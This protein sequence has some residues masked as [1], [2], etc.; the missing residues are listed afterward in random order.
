[1]TRIFGVAVILTAV[2]AVRPGDLIAQSQT[3]SAK[4]SVTLGAYS[5]NFAEPNPADQCHFGGSGAKVSFSFQGEVVNPA[6]PYTVA[7]SGNFSMYH[8]DTG[9]RTQFLSGTALIF[10]NYHRLEVNGTCETRNAAGQIVPFGTGNCFI[11]SEDRTSNGATDIVQ[12]YVSTATGF[13]QACCEAA[14]GN[15]NIE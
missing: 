15:V 5:C 1:M 3:V 11:F 7:T 9:F 14:S 10:R 2:L 12:A 4:G 6:L 13:I 8:P